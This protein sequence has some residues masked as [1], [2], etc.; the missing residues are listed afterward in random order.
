MENED[1]IRDF[2]ANLAE[3]ATKMKRVTRIMD[4]LNTLI[5]TDQTAP[6][7]KAEF[8][9]LTDYV[10]SVEANVNLPH[11]TV[12]LAILQNRIQHSIDTTITMGHYLLD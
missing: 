10:I 11:L 2:D 4:F 9:T 6:F 12:L 8:D 3:W 5:T 1:P 7:T